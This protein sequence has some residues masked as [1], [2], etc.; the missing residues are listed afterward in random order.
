MAKAEIRM[1]LTPREN[2]LRLWRR[3]GFEYAPAFFD[4]CP[5]LVEEFT[6]RYGGA[7]SYEDRFHFPFRQ[8][9]AAIKENRQDWAAYYPGVTFNPGTTIDHGGV[10][11]EPHPGSMHMTRMHH[12][13][14]NFTRLD[15]FKAYP[16]PELRDDSVDLLIPQVT[17]L[18]T[19]G[20]AAMGT[21]GSI[22]EDAWY[23]RSMEDLMV[24]M[25]ADDEKA[26][27]HLD[28]ITGLVRERV[29]ALA[30]AGVD[31]IHLGD[32][33]GMQ[34]AIMMSEALYRAWIKPRFAA[35]IRAAKAVNP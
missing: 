11:H 20:L 35:V 31:V 26:V 34:H 28:R 17:R 15:E 21:P 6:R 4:L 30:R 24:D 9:G 1:S 16:Y 7:E 19:R 25:M 18:H 22:W 5:A 12:P 8:V 29:V 14:R 32:D 27:Y 3:E 10:A 33:I 2:L 13:M 23:M